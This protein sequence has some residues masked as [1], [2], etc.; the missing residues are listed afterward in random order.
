[1]FSQHL[2][3]VFKLQHPNFISLKKDREKPKYIQRCFQWTRSA[4][5]VVGITLT[6]ASV[7]LSKTHSKTLKVS[8]LLPLWR[9][10]LSLQSLLLYTG[11]HQV[12]NIGENRHQIGSDI[13][14]IWPQNN[15]IWW[16]HYVKISCERALY[17]SINRSAPWLE[18]VLSL[19]AGRR[20][21]E[22]D[23]NGCHGIKLC[24][25]EKTCISNEDVHISPTR[26]RTRLYCSSSV[27]Q[28]TN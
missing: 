23:V 1:M 25:R 2:N 3:P 8:H 16:E 14:R 21:K 11:L 20:P 5:D 7:E 9:P 4:D 26:N 28:E 13:T 18:G 15:G 6:S 19:E 10:C 24:V 12:S 22:W 27:A 17:Q